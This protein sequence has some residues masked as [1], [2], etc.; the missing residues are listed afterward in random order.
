MRVLHAISTLNPAHGGPPV[1]L[2]GLATA[3]A[4]AGLDVH[5]VSTFV[6]DPGPAALAPFEQANIP[7]TH[8]GPARDPQSRHPQLAGILD[9]LISKADIVHV[10]A[11]WE[12]IQRLACVTATRRGVPCIVTPHGML[13]RFNMSK[14]WLKKRVYFELRM[15]HPLNRAAS[16]HFATAMERDAVARLRLKS[17]TLVEPF[18]LFADQFENLP[19][20][21][22][23]RSRFPQ[24]GDRPYVMFLGRLDY[25]KGLELLIPAFAAAKN[26]DARLVIVGPDSLSGYRA[27][28]EKMIDAHGLRERTLFTG[29][30]S[31]AD[32]QA[33][34][35]DAH[36][37]CHPSYHENFGI[38]VIEALACGCPV[39]L[40]DQVYLHPELSTAGLATVVPL[41]VAKVT[42]AL[43]RSLSSPRP[44]GDRARAFALDRFNW[45]TIARHWVEHYQRLS[46]R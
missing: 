31:G 19:P 5:V 46:Q 44:D 30:L 34:L 22:T 25:G 41:D 42:S 23:F 8:V 14:N 28:V 40:S 3:Q 16:I 1:A 36:V 35:V 17:P 33:A 27:T 2:A 21:G 6:N 20:P 10:H 15:R 12:Q 43:D 29:L 24:L 11:M 45:Q 4:A 13:D 26:R 7:V 39:I 18:G 32:K 9:Q 37:L 38:V